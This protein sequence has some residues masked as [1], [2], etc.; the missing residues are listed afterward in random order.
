[1][2]E[3]HPRIGDLLLDGRTPRVAVSF[4]R[5]VTRADLQRAR[6]AGADLAELRIDHW[7]DPEPSSLPALG[8]LPLLATIR[9]AREGGAWSRSEAQRLA[10]FEAITPHVDALDVELSAHT[11]LA[12]ARRSARE[13][14]KTLL[15]SSHD[16]TRTP[17]YDALQQTLERARAAGADIVKIATM[18]RSDEDVQTLARLLLEHPT[19]PLVT[20]AMGAHGVKSRVFFPALGSRFTFA[21]INGKPMAPGQLPLEQLTQALE[22]YYP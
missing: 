20:I 21:A 18:A 6:A 7:Q 9:H 12:Q 8:E 1:M 15:I 19:V 11:I 13:H 10:L 2:S 17:R 22:T 4:D 5:P 3:A 14:K 16:F